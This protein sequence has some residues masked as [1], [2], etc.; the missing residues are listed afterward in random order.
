[1]M[2]KPL[3]ALDRID[4]RE[5]S[6]DKL[7]DKKFRPYRDS[8]GDGVVV[9]VIDSGVSPVSSLLSG[10]KLHQLG[11]DAN[12]EVKL[13]TPQDYE[14]HG[15]GVVGILAGTEI[16]VAPK[17]TIVMVRTGYI[18]ENNTY[19][20]P[21]DRIRSALNW[22]RGSIRSIK[23]DNSR[24]F[25][26]AVVN[27]SMGEK[28]N[29]NGPDKPQVMADFKQRVQ[30]I[31][32]EGVPVVI[33]AANAGAQ[34]CNSVFSAIGGD[35]RTNSDAVPG[36]IV[37]GASTEQDEMLDGSNYGRCVD[38]L[39][40]GDRV[41]T[42]NSMGG[43][44]WPSGT[45]FAAP[46]VTGVLALLTQAEPPGT[47]D[48]SYA[49]AIKDKL[50]RAATQ[51]RI[52]LSACDTL[53]TANERDECLKTPNRLLYL[54]WRGIEMTGCA[55]R[56]K[57]QRTPLFQSGRGTH[58]GKLTLDSPLG[59]KD[60]LSLSLKDAGFWS[61]TLAQADA[62]PWEVVKKTS[63]G[64]FHW[65]IAYTSRKSPLTLLDV[66]AHASGDLLAPIPY[67]GYTPQQ[68]VPCLP[69]TLRYEYEIDPTPAPS[70]K[71]KDELKRAT[72]PYPPVQLVDVPA[73]A[74]CS[75][76]RAVDADCLSDHPNHVFVGDFDGDGRADILSANTNFD[77]FFSRGDGTFSLGSSAPPGLSE[78]TASACLSEAPNRVLT[79]D[80]NGDGRT[81]LLLVPEPRRDLI[82]VDPELTLLLSQ[83]DG[84]FF[85]LSGGTTV[86]APIA[87]APPGDDG[88][89]AMPAPEP[90]ESPAQPAPVFAP[91]SDF[92]SA[93][94]PAPSAAGGDPATV[95]TVQVP[96]PGPPPLVSD[97][98]GH[99]VV[100]DIDGDGASDVVSVMEGTSVLTTL[101]SNRNGTFTRAVWESQTRLWPQD[102]LLAGD[103]NGDGLTDLLIVDASTTRTLLSNGDGSFQLVEAPRAF[104]GAPCAGTSAVPRLG[105][106]NGD[107]RT[108]FLVIGESLTVYLAAGD[109]TFVPN[110]A[111]PSGPSGT[112]VC[113]GLVAS[114]DRIFV[115]D[116]DGDGYA[117]LVAAGSPI[118]VWIGDRNGTLTWFPETA[119][120]WP[121]ACPDGC[122]EASPNHT[123]A[124]DLEGNGGLDLFTVRDGRV[125]AVLFD[126]RSEPA[127]RVAWKNGA[128]PAASGDAHCGVLDVMGKVDGVSCEAEARPFMCWNAAG[129]FYVT[130]AWGRWSE[131]F[132]A[133]ARESEG[134]YTFSVPLTLDEAAA[135]PLIGRVGAIEA[136][137]NFSDAIAPGTWQP[138]LDHTSYDGEA[139]WP[140]AAGQPAYG[141]GGHCAAVDGD[142]LRWTR[143]CA[144]M[145]P[146][147]CI[148]PSGAWHISPFI[149][150]FDQGDLACALDGG[151]YVVFSAPAN[152]AE[153]S[154]LADAMR[155]A[156][157][158]D[159][160]VNLTDARA[161]GHWQ[162]EPSRSWVEFSWA[163]LVS[164]WAWAPGAAHVPGRDCAVQEQDG[165]WK[166]SACSDDL[167]HACEDDHGNWA[168]KAR[169]AGNPGDPC[170]ELEGAY[171][172][173]VPANAVENLALA[174]AHAASGYKND[175]IL[176][177]YAFLDPS[178]YDTALPG[179][180][181]AMW[182]SRTTSLPRGQGLAAVLMS[183]SCRIPAAT[184]GNVHP[185]ACSDGGSRWYLTRGAGTWDQG[186]SFCR[187]E[188]HGAYGFDAPVLT[189]QLKRFDRIRRAA[190]EDYVWFNMRY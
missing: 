3:W 105:D 39:A 180:W 121:A 108:D 179:Q 164:S 96:P 116:V 99:V 80:F 184:G 111:P 95:S 42:V 4:Q 133:C 25:K 61:F 69:Y 190:G 77:V 31:T 148:T 152:T 79:G 98:A 41:D 65:K 167:P 141:A 81:D 107:G 8:D 132:A 155:V 75:R 177:D 138:D 102:H 160:W 174:R 89:G 56:D 101:R 149:G 185:F 119:L 140:W 114:G 171:H 5:S 103:F 73:P 122:V 151:G 83:G 22:V 57:P 120:S 178:P 134:H 54:H 58:L 144:E 145:R 70:H 125:R 123:L 11:V 48:S 129:S 118:E 27:I 159:V 172:F 143:D 1:M 52:D 66:L 12:L 51:G 110:V 21:Y 106:F 46:Y 30:A 33:A 163:M 62:W 188:T 165:T 9:Y 142:G 154:E 10:V 170:A 117:D 84:S 91:P 49:Q 169:S 115:G 36:V 156:E 136:W 43:A 128:P 127:A 34:S 93:S 63:T 187:A 85:R 15:T 112:D 157:V 60:Y 189:D 59:D 139:W 18:D 168:V 23:N 88:G 68:T 2:G 6:G 45:S 47:W 97:V 55:D 38:L 53:S 86:D 76:P 113:S 109:G 94:A 183:G 13:E 64:S 162:A 166:P 37:V 72:T 71:N 24:P 87:E 67:L 14:D 20:L 137:V 90:P 131:G 175:P 147:A 130:R 35:A 29:Y 40:P 104:G 182:C 16:G 176:L 158:N 50:L 153:Q 161:T 100:G 78:P 19:R 135:A 44:A 17:V 146:F 181:S 74:F 26:S 186:E 82:V 92:V 28:S 124:A 32:S 7:F 150:S 173:S 126:P